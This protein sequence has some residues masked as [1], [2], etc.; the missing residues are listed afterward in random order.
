[1][2]EIHFPTSRG[3]K[4]AEMHRNLP[5]VFPM[6]RM[7]FETKHFSTPYSTINLNYMNVIWKYQRHRSQHGGEECSLG[8]LQRRRRMQA[9]DQQ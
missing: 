8:R 4:S 2:T 9:D 3:P 7:V 6:Y 1:M 5:L